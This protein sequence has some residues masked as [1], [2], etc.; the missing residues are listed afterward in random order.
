[1]RAEGIA[2]H[3][4]VTLLKRLAEKRLRHFASSAVYYAQ[5]VTKIKFS[6]YKK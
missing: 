2:R 5:S 1:M 3:E 4:G 6:K